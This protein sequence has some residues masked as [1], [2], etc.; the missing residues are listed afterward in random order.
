MHSGGIYAI[1]PPAMKC[2]YL[3][4]YT[5]KRIE[6]KKLRIISLSPKKLEMPK[7]NHSSMS[8]RQGAQVR[9]YICI[10]AW[11]TW[12]PCIQEDSHYKSI[13]LGSNKKCISYLTIID[14]ITKILDSWILI[15]T[16]DSRVLFLLLNR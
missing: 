4:K 8:S 7:A 13:S 2:I 15:Q 3:C 5:Y 12:C 16:L 11:D 14:I 10:I 6:E 1:P 9:K